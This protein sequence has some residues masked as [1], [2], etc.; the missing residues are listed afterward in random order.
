MC[1]LS[2]ALSFHQL[3]NSFDMELVSQIFNGIF[4]SFKMVHLHH[5]YY[6]KYGLK[7]GI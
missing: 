4:N 6:T 5:I 7:V 1:V 3:G 2:Q